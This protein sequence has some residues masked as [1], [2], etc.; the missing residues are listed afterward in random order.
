MEFKH[1][2]INAAKMHDCYTIH[3]SLI[4]PMPYSEGGG[5]PERNKAALRLIDDISGCLIQAMADEF[6]FIGSKYG[7]D[8]KDTV[9]MAMDGRTPMWA[10]NAK[11]K[12]LPSV[13]ELVQY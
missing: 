1:Q 10:T 6:G 9:N 5:D 7:L 13:N 11:P 8:V 4:D 2:N 12:I 3:V